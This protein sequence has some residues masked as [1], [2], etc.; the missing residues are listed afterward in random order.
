MLAA[1]AGIEACSHLI[2]VYQTVV[3]ELVERRAGDAAIGVCATRHRERPSGLCV[4]VVEY[5]RKDDELIF[6]SGLCAYVGD[7]VLDLVPY[8]AR[9]DAAALAVSPPWNVFETE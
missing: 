1:V 9:R 6:V 7:A 3:D 4:D 2:V 5:L 8:V